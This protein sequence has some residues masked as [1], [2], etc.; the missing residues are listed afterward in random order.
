[1]KKLAYKTKVY[2]LSAILAILTAGLVIV[3]VKTVKMTKVEEPETKDPI[4]TEQPEKPEKPDPSV[5]PVPQKDPEETEEADPEK[6]HECY[7]QLLQEKLI[8]E[9]KVA[10][11]S[12]FSFP[13]VSQLGMVTVNAKNSNMGLVGALEYD[14]NGD[15]I[16]EL[17]VL[18]LQ[19]QSR[20]TGEASYELQSLYVDL[21][22]V[23]KDQAVLVQNIDLLDQVYPWGSM[24]LIED[25]MYMGI[26]SY[27]G[28][29]Y[30]YVERETNAE[31]PGYLYTNIYDLTDLYNIDRIKYHKVSDVG[32]YEGNLVYPPEM[33]SGSDTS[34]EF[35]VKEH[36]GNMELYYEAFREPEMAQGIT[37]TPK[38]GTME[39]V[40]TAV[41]QELSE[42]GAGAGKDSEGMMDLL[43]WEFVHG[44][45]PYVHKMEIHDETQWIDKFGLEPEYASDESDI[46]GKIPHDFIFCSGAGAWMTE[47]TIQN[48]GSFA[49]QYHD[50]NMGEIGEGFPNGSVY[51]CNFRGKFS[52]PVQLDPYTYVMNL[53]VME[54]EDEPGREYIDQ[55]VRFEATTPYGLENAGRVFLYMPGKSLY[56]LSEDFVRWIFFGEPQDH[57]PAGC[58]VLHNE[59]DETGFYT[60]QE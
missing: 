50:S 40:L 32:R 8:P 21:Y 7:R 24:F 53:E 45:D 11:L 57:V 41:S 60:Q 9:Y 37:D 54:M 3:V 10:D 26:K 48:D 35:L 59:N 27:E 16:Q 38:Y 39:E 17:I 31:G 43:E 20:G 36:N 15:G 13:D 25:H 33:G 30:L 34:H 58:Y 55:G 44:Y 29:T 28:H 1:M 2:I 4:V 6:V 5:E 52:R 23:E 14:C 46:L 18:Y 49:G 47:L 56:G 42:L 12:D 51:Y 22:T 19:K